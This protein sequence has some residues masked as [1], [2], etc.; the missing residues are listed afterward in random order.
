MMILISII[1]IIFI[2]IDAFYDRGITIPLKWFL[3]DGA[4]SP[5]IVAMPIVLRENYIF[6]YS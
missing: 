1:T 6:I 4:P 3:S 5:K 2:L